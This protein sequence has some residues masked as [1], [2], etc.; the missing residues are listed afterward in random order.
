MNQPTK[1][2]VC[3]II[4]LPSL[5]SSE[6]TWA[7]GMPLE[8][9][10][11]PDESCRN[12]GTALQIESICS[13]C[14]QA[15]QQICPECGYATLERIHSDCTRGLEIMTVEESQRQV[16]AVRSGWKVCPKMVSSNPLFSCWKVTHVI[17]Q[18]W[19]AKLVKQQQITA[20][21]QHHIWTKRINVELY[22]IELD[23]IRKIWHLLYR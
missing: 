15:I 21:Q 6:S 23:V 5:A 14:R 10:K 16:H 17:D 4:I 3:R 8:G 22:L 19:Y 18:N 1:S 9:E 12:C 11:M 7:K 20:E 2:E 13:E